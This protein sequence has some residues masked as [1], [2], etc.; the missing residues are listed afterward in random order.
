MASSAGR[1]GTAADPLLLAPESE[2]QEKSP[3]GKK[4]ESKSP[5]A[6]ELLI[7]ARKGHSKDVARLLD[8]DGG[9]AAVTVLDKVGVYS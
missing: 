4:K 5:L 2:T 3:K 7:A 8:Q 1:H 6:N 9:V